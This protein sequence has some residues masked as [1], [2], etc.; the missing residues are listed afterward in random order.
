MVS[1]R[2]RDQLPREVDEEATVLAVTATQ[3]VLAGEGSV[4]CRGGDRRS[5]LFPQ[6]TVLSGTNYLI[7]SP[8]SPNTPRYSGW[9]LRKFA[10]WYRGAC[11]GFQGL[12]ALTELL[13][14][15]EGVCYV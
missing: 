9:Q 12:Y 7:P 14:L 15:H 1:R 4:A 2:Q 10:T 13:T 6:Q 8:F 3:L 5:L 11:L